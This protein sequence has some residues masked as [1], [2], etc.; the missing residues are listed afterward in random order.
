MLSILQPLCFFLEKNKAA[1]GCTAC[2]HNT[3]KLRKKKPTH[4][5]PFFFFCAP[6]Q[7]TA[8]AFNIIN[9][10]KLSRDPTN[11]GAKQV[12]RP[13]LRVHVCQVLFDGSKKKNEHPKKS[14]S[15]AKKFLPLDCWQA[16]GG[17]APPGRRFRTGAQKIPALLWRCRPWQ[18]HQP[19]I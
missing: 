13:G 17:V 12:T 15:L 10:I 16:G 4:R 19:V 2:P 3:A 1:A 6:T 18:K 7:P 11:K 9:I 8:Q 14:S 5:K